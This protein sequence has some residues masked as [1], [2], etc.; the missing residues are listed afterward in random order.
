MHD[1]LLERLK[2]LRDEWKSF[3]AVGVAG[4]ADGQ[5]MAMRSCGETL[6]ELLKELGLDKYSCSSSSQPECQE[7]V[8]FEARMTNW[9]ETPSENQDCG[10]QCFRIGGKFIAEDPDCPVHG[11]SKEY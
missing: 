8:N 3:H 4:F 2:Q 9:S 11:R 6:E 1:K 7:A 10:H 5:E